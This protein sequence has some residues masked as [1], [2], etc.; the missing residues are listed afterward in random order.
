MP[1]EEG[2][3]KTEIFE[4][5][6]EFLKVAVLLKGAEL[7]SLKN[8]QTN[9]E[10]IWQADPEIWSSHAPNLFPIIGALKD[11]E[12][13]FDGKYYPLTRHGFIRNNKNIQLKEQSENQ[14]VFQF[15]FSEETLR[16]YPFKFDFEIAFTLK[17]KTLTISHKIINLDNKPMYFSLG[18]HPAFNAPL[19]EGETYQD[20]Y[21]EFD[22]KLNLKTHLLNDEGLISEETAVVTRNDS[23]I[24]LHQNLFD[25]DALIFKNIASK[26]V[27]LKSKKRGTILSVDYKDFEHLGIWAK[28]AAP[29]VCIEPWLGYADVE[30]TTKDLKTKEGII[31]LMPSETFNAFYT[32]T[33]A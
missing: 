18:G 33:I 16:L 12:V 4:I 5:Q 1:T 31:E 13:I 26:K 25:N 23:K 10:H 20:Y 30:G 8:L 29:F 6:N 2:R 22:Q 27:A 21:L 14:L 17:N 7:C 11:G 28:P 19:Y 9:T 24:K 15:P 3:S 32:I